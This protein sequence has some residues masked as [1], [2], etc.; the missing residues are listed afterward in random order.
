MCRN[1]IYLFSFILVPG[2]VLTNSA[3]AELVGWWRFNEGSGST[4]TDSSGNGHDGTVIGTPQWG[5][6]PEGFGPALVF[7]PDIYQGVDCGVFDPTDGTG[8]FSLT[9]WAFWDGTG[10]F[11]HFF[12]KSNGWGADTLM[13]QVELWGA[14][15]SAQYTD[16]VGVSSVSGGSVEFSIMPKNSGLSVWRYLSASSCGAQK[17]K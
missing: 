10:T 11:Q 13:F 17:G 2:I 12:T 3:N 16:R 1:L 5:T 15:T 7:N 14:H 8:Q 4:C 6:G 9:L